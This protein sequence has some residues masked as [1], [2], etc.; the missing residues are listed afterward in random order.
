MLNPEGGNELIDTLISAY[1]RSA[2]PVLE[3]L[4]NG[5]TTGDA[6]K[7]IQAAH[8]LKSSNHN[9]GATTLGETFQ[10][11][12]T[13]ARQGDFEAIHLRMPLMRKEWSRVE[14]ALITLQT[15]ARA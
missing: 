7:V 9:V 4:Q 6:E 14:K 15:E 10:D 8:K 13:L 12:E 5:L 3:T 11:I 2:Q 1:L